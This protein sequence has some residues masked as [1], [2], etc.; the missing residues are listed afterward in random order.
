MN[1]ILLWSHKKLDGLRIRIN[2][3][4]FRFLFN[5][6]GPGSVVYGRIK[7]LHPE[8]IIVGCY[9]TL[10]EGVIL[11]A[12]DKIIIGNYVHISPMSILTAG[13]LNIQEDYRTRAHFAREIVVS[14]G[15]WIGSHA[16]I[17]PGVKIGRNSIIGAGAVVTKD[18]PDNAV[19]AGVP[20]RII[21]R[22]EPRRGA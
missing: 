6:L 14:D 4:Y 2:T 11:N 18:V 19:V 3:I 13:G 12:R 21:K 22:L 15:A 5:Q 8:N 20:A 10:N 16:T 7:V 1:R 9:C 17:L